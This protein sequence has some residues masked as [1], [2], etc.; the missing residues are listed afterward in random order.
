MGPLVLGFIPHVDSK[1]LLTGKSELQTHAP[2]RPPTP[3][4]PE[5]S[6]LERQGADHCFVLCCLLTLPLHAEPGPPAGRCARSSKPAGSVDPLQTFC[7]H[8][9][10]RQRVP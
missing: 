5:E 6:H 10:L 2:P 7:T 8:A 1:S 3:D 9:S 4:H